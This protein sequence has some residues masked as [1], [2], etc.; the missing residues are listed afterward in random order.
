MQRLYCNFTCA[1]TF[2]PAQAIYRDNF[3]FKLAPT[4]IFTALIS[5]TK[6][7]IW[8]FSWMPPR[9]T[10][11]AVA[12]RLLRTPGIEHWIWIQ[13]NGLFPFENNFKRTINCPVTRANMN[14]PSKGLTGVIIE[15]WCTLRN[16]GRKLPF[17][18]SVT[19]VTEQRQVQARIRA[20]RN[21][22]DASRV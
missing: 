1:N 7:Q 13:S 3:R 8:R 6:F 9:T 11:N 2:H 4:L 15:L 10:E 14:K 5:W 16:N 22:S 19:N 20:K 17:H 21:S 12:G 18:C